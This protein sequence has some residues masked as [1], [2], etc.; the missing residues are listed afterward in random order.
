[1]G[2]CV[3]CGEKGTL[4]HLLKTKEQALDAGLRCDATNFLLRRGTDGQEVSCPNL[5]DKGSM[6]FLHVHGGDRT[7]WIV[8]GGPHHGTKVTIPFDSCPFRPMY[9]Q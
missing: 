5:F 7:K 1:M 4:A 3:V 9:D 2:D 8:V 6:S